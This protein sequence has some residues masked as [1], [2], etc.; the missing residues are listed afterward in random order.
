MAQFDFDKTRKQMLSEQTLTKKFAREHARSPSGLYHAHA[1]AAKEA[2]MESQA[3][4]GPII[5]KLADE[6]Q[7]Q[8]P[9]MG[10]HT[11]YSIAAKRLGII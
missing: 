5:K 6:I 2:R 4:Q 1:R 8:Y 9:S 7:A 11:C 3:E 10:L